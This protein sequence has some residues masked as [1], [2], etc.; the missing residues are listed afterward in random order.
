MNVGEY[1]AKRGGING[2]MRSGH[3]FA[4][5][6]SSDGP[7]ILVA[8]GSRG[9]QNGGFWVQ[10]SAVPETMESSRRWSG[11]VCPDCRFVFRVP[12]DHDGQGIVCPSCRRMLRIPRVG[13]QTPLLVASI[14]SVEAESVVEQV[15]ETRVRRRK[16]KRTGESQA[17]ERSDSSGENA[18]QDPSASKWWLA[19]GAVGLVGVIVAVVLLMRGSHQ[20]EGEPIA[21]DQGAKPES[22]V[23]GGPAEPSL[24]EGLEN[25][26]SD[27]EF[28]KLA[29]PI[30]K[31]FMEAG[32]IDDLLPLVRNPETAEPR[33]RAFYPE[34]AY[35]PFAY[36]K[37][38]TAG[39]VQT[40]GSVRTIMMANSDFEEKPLVFEESPSGIKIDWENWVRWSEMSW[41]DFVTAK[42]VSGKL[43]PVVLSAVDYYNFDFTDDRKWRSYRLTSPDGETSIYGY[44]KR[45][46]E[47]ESKLR[48]P[49]DAT[50]S[51]LILKLKYPEVP[52]S[53]NQVLIEGVVAEGWVFPNKTSP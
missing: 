50:Q 15:A 1:A 31:R 35:K 8:A 44:V 10:G 39:S 36:S 34:G 49:S 20:P 53:S 3:I 19:G 9:L 52:V 27:V 5:F 40:E 22:L 29:E 13:E 11:F 25:L 24:P 46:S 21:V 43:F 14:R 7:E 30:A 2:G 16:R 28:L 17:W 4:A 51:Q 12:R 48:L 33:I 26:R 45:D 37:F 47:M 23:P 38:N 32:S 41:A 42:P 18:R 6:D